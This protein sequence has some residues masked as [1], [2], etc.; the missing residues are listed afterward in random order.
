MKGEVRLDLDICP[1]PRVPSHATGC[2][3]PSSRIRIVLL[4]ITEGVRNVVVGA[5]SEA[6]VALITTLRAT[7]P[8]HIRASATT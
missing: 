2:Q 6:L 8:R 5:V 4:D 3:S 7:R 1:G